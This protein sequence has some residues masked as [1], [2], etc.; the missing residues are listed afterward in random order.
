LNHLKLRVPGNPPKGKEIAVLNTEVGAPW[1]VV[2]PPTVR[3]TGLRILPTVIYT[4]FV[5]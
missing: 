2:T 5:V 4:I 3:D 1:I